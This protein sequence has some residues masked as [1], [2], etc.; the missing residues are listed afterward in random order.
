MS[1]I[2]WNELN[3]ILKPGGIIITLCPSW[4]HNYR[5]YYEDFTHVSPFQKESLEDIH[6]ISGFVDINVI[7]FNNFHLFGL[8]IHIFSAFYRKLLDCFYPITVVDLTSGY[9][10]ARR[11]CF[12]LLHTS[13]EST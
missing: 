1:L 6:T 2:V 13:D 10:L 4:E 8:V 7:F 11:S 3:R 12:F 5:W 9:V